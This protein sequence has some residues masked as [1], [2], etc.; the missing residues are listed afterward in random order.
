MAICNG[1][2]PKSDQLRHEALLTDFLL[3]YPEAEL[4]RGPFVDSRI[5]PDAE[6]TFPDGRF[7]YV[8]F[9]TGLQS[10]SAVLRRQRDAYRDVQQ[11]VLY[12]TTS[13]RRLSGLVAHAELVK[14][15]AVFTCLEDVLRDPQG[16]IWIDAQGNRGAL[17]LTRLA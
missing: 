13:Q 8:E 14:D 16:E 12:V 6:L 3:C 4:V 9:D 11:M 5:R 10:H 2:R 7:F 1:W 17:G 15:I